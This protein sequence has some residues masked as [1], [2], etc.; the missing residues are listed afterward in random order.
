[1]KYAINS[2]FLRL[3]LSSHFWKRLIQ[4]FPVSS[5][6]SSDSRSPDPVRRSCRQHLSVETDSESKNFGKVFRRNSSQEFDLTVQLKRFDVV[7]VGKNEKLAYG[8][9]WSAKNQNHFYD[10]DKANFE[11]FNFFEFRLTFLRKI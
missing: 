8:L 6:A 10:W 11:I 7:Q 5:F 4:I 1:M 3:D 2:A 9:S